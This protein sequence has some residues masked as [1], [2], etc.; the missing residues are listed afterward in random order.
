VYDGPWPL[1]E[2]A[3]VWETPASDFDLNC[4]YCPFAPRPGDAGMRA[5]LELAHSR[6]GG[7]LDINPG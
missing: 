4:R 3:G 5:L 6:P 2:G 7:V 1:P